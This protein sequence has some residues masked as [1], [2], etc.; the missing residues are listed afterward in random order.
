MTNFIITSA[1]FPVGRR[2]AHLATLPDLLRRFGIPPEIDCCHQ[3]TIRKTSSSNSN[4]ARSRLSYFSKNSRRSL[5]DLWDLVRARWRKIV[6]ELHPDRGGN[7]HKFAVA[8][9]IHD[10]I[11]LRLRKKGIYPA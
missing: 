3:T 1:R 2:P 10:M 8:S 9:E 4:T 5:W 6:W 7:T 11:L